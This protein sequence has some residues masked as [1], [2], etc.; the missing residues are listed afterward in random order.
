MKK[1]F[2]AVVLILGMMT[3]QFVGCND[4]GEDA[5]LE[6]VKIIGTTDI[7]VETTITEV[8]NTES[9]EHMGITELQESDVSV[10]TETTEVTA[11]METGPD[12]TEN[13]QE[14]G[15]NE[16]AENEA[17]DA[18]LNKDTTGRNCK[19]ESSEGREKHS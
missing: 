5:S 7:D 8:Q 18:N 10:V 19:D 14:K 17:Y 3:V 13:S 4:V 16:D 12:L 9:P 6:V 1:D 2:V 11:S 15:E